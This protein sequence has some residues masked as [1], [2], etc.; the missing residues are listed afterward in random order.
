[1]RTTKKMK[2]KA[3]MHN[4]VNLSSPTRLK[5]I[6]MH[7]YTLC[8]DYLYIILSISSLFSCNLANATPIIVKIHV[9]GI[10]TMAMF[11]IHKTFVERMWDPLLFEFWFHL[12]VWQ[13]I[14]VIWGIIQSVLYPLM[15]IHALCLHLWDFLHWYWHHFT[16]RNTSRWFAYLFEIGLFNISWW[17]LREHVTVTEYAFLKTKNSIFSMW[18]WFEMFFM[19]VWKH[20]TTFGFH[21]GETMHASQHLC[22]LRVPSNESTRPG[23]DYGHHF[24]LTEQLISCIGI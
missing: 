13:C 12:L 16:S 18:V 9:K 4:M 19:H 15:W 21:K 14:Y 8:D 5:I 7:S 2:E 3:F 11:D 20:T 22:E 17:L 24:W 10:R 6:F 1:M 23:C